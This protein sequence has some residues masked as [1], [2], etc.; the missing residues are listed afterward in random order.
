MGD[1]VGKTPK[2]KSC[3]EVACC[4][5]KACLNQTGKPGRAVRRRSPKDIIKENLLCTCHRVCCSAACL[6]LH[7]ELKCDTWRGSLY[8]QD[9]NTLVKIGGPGRKR[10]SD[11]ASGQG[12]ALPAG[13]A[14]ASGQADIA[15]VKRGAIPLSDQPGGFRQEASFQQFALSQQAHLHQALPQQGGL[16][17]ALSQQGGQQQG[18]PHQSLP[19]QGGPNQA[20][21]QQGGPHQSFPQQ[22]GPHQAILQQGGQQQGGPHQSLPQQGGPHQALPQQTFQQQAPPQQTFPRQAPLQQTLPQQVLPQQAHPQPAHPQQAFPQQGLPQQAVAPDRASYDP[23][24][25]QLTLP[26]QPFAPDRVGH[27]ANIQQ[28]ALPQQFQAPDRSQGGDATRAP[29]TDTDRFKSLYPSYFQQ[30]LTRGNG[31][32]QHAPHL[33]P[34]NGLSESDVQIGSPSLPGRAVMDR[35]GTGSIPTSGAAHHPTDVSP[36]VSVV[37]SGANA[38]PLNAGPGPPQI[39][40]AAA[41]CCNAAKEV[42]EMKKRL[43]FAMSELERVKLEAEDSVKAEADAAERLE[44]QLEETQRNLEKAKAESQK[45]LEQKAGELETAK[46]DLAVYQGRAQMLEQELAFV[47]QRLS[48]QETD[49]QRRQVNVATTGEEMDGQ[50]QELRRKLHST[51]SLVLHLTGLSSQITTDNWLQT[52]DCAQQL[53][54]Q[55]ALKGKAPTLGSAA[56]VTAPELR[57]SNALMGYAPTTAKMP[58]T[59]SFGF[60]TQRPS[61]PQPPWT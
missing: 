40:E 16:H 30:D 54:L 35:A 4:L 48:G 17:Q 56:P 21:S 11:L 2:S 46:M 24:L 33:P 49:L 57:L 51:T 31:S 50:V 13:Q 39:S 44:K 53:L 25:Q 12:G 8:R 22:G 7:K 28:P 36:A 52:P 18:G 32:A 60:P 37:L 41:A 45:A 15:V 6:S 34:E 38:L 19:Q 20:L 43:K 55:Y 14:D 10:L 23:N 3:Y 47:R 26:A 27:E 61:G 9:G 5:G 29:T 58:D 1:N 42:A 59:T